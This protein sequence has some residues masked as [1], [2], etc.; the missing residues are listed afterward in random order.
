MT[1]TEIFN[2]LK[3]ILLSEDERNR[4][5]LESCTEETELVSDLNLNSVGIL[6]LVI[7]IEETF[8]IR[9]ENSGIADFRTVGDVITYI[10]SKLGE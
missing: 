6:Y 1:R 2:E 3:S 4:E 7:S 8:Q 9:F 10:Q 5:L